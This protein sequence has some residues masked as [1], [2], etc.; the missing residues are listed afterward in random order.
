MKK[1]TQTKRLATNGHAP[2]DT[3]PWD[4]AVAEGSKLWAKIGDAERDQLRLGELAHKV[5][6]PIYGEETFSKFAAKLGIDE[7]TLGHF[8]T[9]Y[10]AW[11]DILPPGAKFPSFAVLRELATHPNRAELIKAEPKMTKRRA[12]AHRV[13]RTLPHPEKILSK[14]PDLS[15]A[16]EARK[17]I[18]AYEGGAKETKKVDGGPADGWSVHREDFRKEGLL[19]ANKISAMKKSLLHC[20]PEQERAIQNDLDPVWWE[21]M[22]QAREDWA[23]VLDRRN[24]ALEAE[25]DTLISEAGRVR[26]T[27]A[28][29]SV[30]PVQPQPGG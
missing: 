9:T 22:E 18:S 16:S 6:H 7:D 2:A 28:R 23:W 3:I 13:L 24:G 12:E 10:R 11:K 4:D 8:R 26:T 21:Q 29:A 30:D 17:A 15:S 5:V 19:I 14:Y 25:A 1:S 20:T 27:P